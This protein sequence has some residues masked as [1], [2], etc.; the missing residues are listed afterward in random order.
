MRHFL[1]VDD[2]SPAELEE[3]IDLGLAFSDED[4]FS[5]N[6]PLKNKGVALLFEKSSLRTRHS[7][8]MAVAKL[9]GHPVATTASEIGMGLRESA[10]DIANTLAGYHSAIGARV[11]S[12]DTLIEMTEAFENSKPTKTKE[13]QSKEAQSKETQS[14][15]AQTDAVPIINLLSDFSHPMQAL[16]DL[17]TIKQEFASFDGI[18]I[19]YIGD[20]NNVAHSLAVA[21]S[22]L[23]KNGKN[24]S[25]QIACPKGYTFKDNLKDNTI[26]KDDTIKT[27]ISKITIAHDPSQ[28]VEGANVLY[29]DVWTSMGQ[30]DEHKKRLKAFKGFSVTEELMAKAKP[31]AIFLHCLP[32][33]RGEE[34]EAAVIDGK[35]SRVFAQAQNR[36]HSAMGLLSWLFREN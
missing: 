36:M 3:V 32:A 16:A 7:M 20:A 23:S 22:L 1:E 24:I 18:K 9:G 31:E 28:A 6:L 35:Q 14:K 19:A 5:N 21:V 4:N 8:E 26:K 29:T 11:F 10:A 30:E 25:I 13:T 15:E 12:H 33:H 34:V 17:L 2:L 27:D